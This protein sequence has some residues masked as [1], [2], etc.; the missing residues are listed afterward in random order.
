M[1]K[2]LDKNSELY[3]D[4]IYF[5]TMV[6]C[7][8]RPPMILSYQL[9]KHHLVKIILCFTGNSWLERL[10]NIP[11]NKEAIPWDLNVS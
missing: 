10:N 3:L 7:N 2:T 1:T 9:E 11:S 6:V 4:R 5:Y 8:R